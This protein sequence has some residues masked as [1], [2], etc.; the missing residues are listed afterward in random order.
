MNDMNQSIKSTDNKKKSI[1]FYWFWII[2]AFLLILLPTLSFDF[3]ITFDEWMDSN[4]GLLHLRYLLS[5]GEDTEFLNFWHGIYYSYLI[6]PIAGIVYGFLSGEGIVKFITDGI[7]QNIH[8]IPFYKTSHFI[9]SLFGFFAILFTG[10]TAK[11]IGTWRTAVI[12][13]VF[14]ALSPRFLGHSMNNPKDIPFAAAYIFSLFCII[15][16]VKELPRIRI[17]TAILVAFSIALAIGSRIAGVLM[18]FYLVLFVFLKYLFSISK[19]S[20]NWSLTKTVGCLLIIGILSY[21]GS[22]IFWPYAQMNPL[23]NPLK[24]FRAMSGFS[25]WD[26]PVLFEGVYVN[27]SKLPWYYIPKWILIT[28]PLF[29]VSGFVLWIPFF[30]KIIKSSN[31]KYILIV[32]FTALFPIVAII[33]KKSTV[34]DG[35]RHVLFVYPPLVIVAAASWDF[36]FCFV[37]TRTAKIFLTV[38]LLLHMINPFIWIVR[39]HPNEYVYFNPIVGGINGALGRYETDYWGNSIR[40][41]AEWIGLY[42]RKHYPNR[43]AIVRADGHFMSSYPFIKEKV[44]GFYKP[45]GYKPDFIKTTPFAFIK[46]PPY[47][48]AADTWNYAILLSREENAQSLREGKWPPPGAIYQVKADNA[49]LCAVM[50]GRN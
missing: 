4:N 44:G 43:P 24:A 2:T 12:A 39:N 10:L 28:V 27:A 9:N 25:F 1:Y 48:I 20:G 33:L 32:L 5:G 41:A 23:L 14:I 3:G 36:L 30:K 37:K 11:K 18:Y 22:M 46:Y 31:F 7:H 21:L 16:F 8:I 13:I 17:R 29:V 35:W 40:E 6:Y 47:P 45:Y 50:K 15:C 19:K 38:L 26:G 42:H 49:V 34:Y